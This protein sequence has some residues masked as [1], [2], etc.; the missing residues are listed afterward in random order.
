V[1]DF[2]LLK[3]K[4]FQGRRILLIVHPNPDPDALGSIFALNY[5]CQEHLKNN[6]LPPDQNITLYSIDPPHFSLQE[7]FPIE[8][9][10]TRLP[11]LENFDLLIFLDRGNTFNKLN[12][13]QKLESLSSKPTIINLDHH[14]DPPLKGGIIN[15]IDNQ[16]AATC[17][18]I[19]QFFQA[20]NFSF[21]PFV[22]QYLLAGIFSDTGG[23]RH[24]N[25]DPEVLEVSG[26]L[27]SRGASLSKI[28]KVLLE[29]KSLRTLKIWSIAL[30]RATVNPK[31]GM[32]ASFI[33]EEDLKKIGATPEDLNGLSE[34]LNT[35]AGSRFSLVLSEYSDNKIKAS[36][37]SEK[38]KGVDVAQ[39]A[40]QFQGGGHQLSSGFEI[41]GKLKQQGDRWII[42]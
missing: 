31:T 12:F 3:E 29:K 16:A 2:S 26:K 25:T 34:I 19:Y 17:L 21:P 37:R 35:I 6:H 10:T 30:E 20:V 15:L 32:A 41:K 1:L 22:A 9:I 23:F 40:R 18:L 5:Y 39:I 42:E 14:N 33:T 8:K 24:S 7:L 4:I 13:P 27:M 36:L 28:K 38:H 11:N